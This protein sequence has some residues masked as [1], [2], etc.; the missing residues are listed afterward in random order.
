MTIILSSSAIAPVQATTIIMS[1]NVFRHP[2]SYTLPAAV[3]PVRTAHRDDN[4]ARH[5]RTH[6]RRARATWIPLQNRRRRSNCPITNDINHYRNIVVLSPI[7]FFFPRPAVVSDTSDRVTR[8]STRR[9][10]VL[11]KLTTSRVPD[12]FVALR[13]SS[14]PCRRSVSAQFSLFACLN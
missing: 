6:S 7:A 10:A 5:R 2:K 11:G 12:V 13:R 14:Q 1:Y 3:R 9:R 8:V 4:T